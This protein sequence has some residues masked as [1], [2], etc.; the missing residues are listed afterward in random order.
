M[1]K[2]TLLFLLLFGFISVVF[3]QTLLISQV[4]DPNDIYQARFVEIHNLSGAEIDFDVV[5]WYLARYSNNNATSSD[6]K[7][8]GVIAIDG[9]YV[10][11]YNQLYFSDA[12][13]FSPNLVSGFINGN[14]NDTYA[15]YVG[16]NSVT[17]TLLDI[18]GEI[19]V[20]GTGEPWEYLD[21]ASKRNSSVTSANT[22][23]TASEWTITR[24]AAT[25]DLAPLPVQ[26]TSF[27]ANTTK[28]GVVL[29]WAT[30]TEVNNYGFEIESQILNQVQNDKS[31]WEKVGFVE[32]H[33]NSNSP[34]EYSFVDPVVAERSRSYRLKQIDFNGGYEYSDIVTVSESLA[35][36]ELFQNSPNPFNPSTKIS[37]SLAEAGKVNVS[38]YNVIGQK[39][40]ELVN[41]NMESGI[42]NVDFNA[43]KLSSGFYIY[44]LETPN[45]VKTMK[46]ILIK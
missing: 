32:G 36:T 10:V 3:G 2:I 12:Y 25:T 41:K 38:V 15:L 21:G 34:K 14:G 26:L 45:F 29:N 30:A 31:L 9:Y 22:I 13:G 11:A 5:D 20:D 28:T 17:G 24:P 19:G 7:L 4:A 43:S 16:G 42:H 1:K 23:W 6:I 8:S 27:T 35:K 46:M 18:Y 37:F 33:G 39:V 40:A 44:K